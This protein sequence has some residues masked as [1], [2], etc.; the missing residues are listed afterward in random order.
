MERRGTLRLRA[1]SSTAWFDRKT[2]LVETIENA[3]EEAIDQEGTVGYPAAAAMQ[4]KVVVAQRDLAART[5]AA[6]VLSVPLS[7]AGRPVGALTL[8]RN[9]GAAFDADSVEPVRGGGRAAR[10]GA[11]G[12]ARERALVRRTRRGRARAN[13]ATS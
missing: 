2:Q 1:I 10:P 5:G 12:Q 9:Q 11:A 8:E 3:M 6:A 7:S 4:G 13:S